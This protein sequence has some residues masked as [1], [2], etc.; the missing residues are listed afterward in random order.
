[1]IRNGYKIEAGADLRGADLEGADLEGATLYKADLRGANLVRTDLRGADLEGTYLVGADLSH[2]KGV[3]SFYL[4]KHF[5]FSYKREGSIYVQI[6][7]EHHE[8][9][10]WL[11]HVEYIGKGNLYTDKEIRRY[12]RFLKAIRKPDFE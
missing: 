12:K 7:C 5:G 2:A 10:N 4:G 1:M 8:L 9:D 3:I 6:G 11:R